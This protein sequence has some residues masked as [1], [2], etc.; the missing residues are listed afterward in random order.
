MRLDGSSL[1]VVLVGDWNRLYSKPEWIAQNIYEE[2]EIEI[3]INKDW[4]TPGFNVMYKKNNVLISPEQQMVT[5]T[6]TDISDETLENLAKF[7]TNYLDKAVTPTLLAYGFN[8][9]FSDSNATLFAE[10]ID[11]MSD[12]ISLI[13]CGYSIESTRIEKSL[14]KDGKNIK[15]AMAF[16]NNELNLHFNEHHGDIEDLKPTI[17]KACLISFIEQCKSIVLALGYD[18]EGDEE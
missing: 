16:A 17:D 2:N 11:D 7:I 14:V 4:E 10:S 8:L 12:S 3:S 1:T 15:L 13:E 5:F 9:E 18:L 6:S